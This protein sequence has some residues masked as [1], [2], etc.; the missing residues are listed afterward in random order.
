MRIVC[1]SDTHSLH[2]GLVIP[3]GDLLIHAGDMS[4]RGKESEI[5]DFDR[6]LGSLPHRNKVVIAGNHDFNFERSP[7]SRA[8][9]TNARYLEDDSVVVGGL[10]I[11]GSP[12]QPRFYDWA[13]NLDRGAPIRAK[14]DRIPVGTDVL[15]THGPPMGIFDRTSRG[16]H[17][18][19]EEL[20]DAVRRI[21]PHV[22]IFGHIHE[23]PGLR[24]EDGTTFVNASTCNLDY[25]PVQPPIVV[26]LP[27]PV[28]RI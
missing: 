20:R 17:V 5:R 12:W 21:R 4:R 14:W 8:W 22:H 27:G 19:C 26:D 16:E 3:D 24:E 25:R 13:F 23:D 2:D 15:I 18:G 9:I 10:R 1:I 6:W 28:D 11:Y 7:S